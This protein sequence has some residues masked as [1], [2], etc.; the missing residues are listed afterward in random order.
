MLWYQGV[1]VLAFQ[2]HFPFGGAPEIRMPCIEILDCT[3]VTRK[4][5]YIKANVCS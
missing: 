5:Y 2:P 4:R 1:V 3:L